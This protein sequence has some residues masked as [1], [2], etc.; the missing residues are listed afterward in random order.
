[1]TSEEGAGGA[2]QRR[3]GFAG[4]PL[5][6]RQSSVRPQSDTEADTA[7]PHSPMGRRRTLIAPFAEGTPR[8][9]ADRW[10]R[11]AQSCRAPLCYR[12]VS[13]L[14]SVE[15]CL[16]PWLR[17]MCALPIPPCNAGD[18]HTRHS[19]GQTPRIWPHRTFSNVGRGQ[20]K[21]VSPSY[22]EVSLAQTLP[23]ASSSQAW[24]R[25]AG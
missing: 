8:R 24:A 18:S 23:T 7:P 13:K 14:C 25:L 15:P 22:P 19:E 12:R 2:S 11:T 4:C 3:S 16:V 10:A 20:K 1:M 9:G 21:C 5:T 17:G 6:V